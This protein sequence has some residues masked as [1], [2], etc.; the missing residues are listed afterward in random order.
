MNTNITYLLMAISIGASF[1][2]WNRPE[3]FGKLMMNPYYIS[4]RREYFRFI[5]SGFIHKDHMHL[6]FNMISFYF[7]G[8]AV[9]MIFKI[10]FPGLGGL[11]F[12]LFYL[13]AIVVSDIPT[14]IKHRNNISYNSL[15]ASGAVSAVIFAFII[16][17]PLADICL[18]FAL[19]LP[20]FI[21]GTMYIIFSYYQGR[22]AN[23]NI[24][25]DAH[26]YGALFGLVFCAVFYP[27][28]IPRFFEQV[29]QWDLLEKIF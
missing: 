10:I 15:G 16:F 4:K 29:Q 27:Q 23:D 22:K 20:G 19:C 28:S 21:L 17:Q 11:Y 6:L 8:R 3:L 2:A 25:H 5:T 24:N 12:I 14:F 13:V 18:F 26:L 1:L 7:F 9:E